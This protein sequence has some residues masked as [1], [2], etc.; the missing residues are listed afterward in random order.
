MTF[1]QI[2]LLSVVLIVQAPSTSAT[3]TALNE[4]TSNW[5]SAVDGF[6][7]MNI[8]ALGNEFNIKHDDVLADGIGVFCSHALNDPITMDLFLWDVPASV[9]SSSM[10]SSSE[11]YL[12]RSLMVE[13]LPQTEDSWQWF[14][15]DEKIL[16][17]DARYIVMAAFHSGVFVQ[18]ADGY[19]FTD[20]KY[21]T[22]Y[23]SLFIINN[24]HVPGSNV[25][26]IRMG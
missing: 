11:N 16:K 17:R 8:V 9:N 2:W 24:K 3:L 12:S 15:I 19:N 25:Y 14:K 18:S 26:C 13:L 23:I 21:S 20:G 10:D 5:I 7:M 22:Y 4:Q 1:L 6:P